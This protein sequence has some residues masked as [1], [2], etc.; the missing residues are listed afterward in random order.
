MY[1]PVMVRPSVRRY[2]LGDSTFSRV[3]STPSRSGTFPKL[4]E[5]EEILTSDPPASVEEEKD[6]FELC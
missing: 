3:D 6:F 5:V 1:S 2:M 4:I